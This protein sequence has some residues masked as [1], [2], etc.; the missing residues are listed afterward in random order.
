MAKPTIAL[1]QHL[2]NRGLE[3]DAYFPH[4]AVHLLSQKQMVLEV[5][6]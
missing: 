2:I 1:N 5:E 3:K 4:Q 6:Q